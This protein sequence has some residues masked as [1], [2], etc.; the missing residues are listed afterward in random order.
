MHIRLLKTHKEYRRAEEI[1]KTVWGFNE[2]GVIPS[3]ELITIQRNGGVVL[4]AFEKDKMIGF[5]FGIVGYNNKKVYHCSRM[6]A[7]LPG[8]Q[9]KGIGF[10]LKL[11]QRRFVLRQGLELIRWTFDP[12]QS[13]NAYF[14]IRKLGVIIR[15]YAVNLYGKS[16][17]RFDKG[18]PTDRFVPEWW[19]KSDRVR[20]RIIGEEYVNRKDFY[21]ANITEIRN[22]LPI[23]KKVVLEA[24]EP[25]V[26]I[27]IPENF[28]MLKNRNIALALKWRNVSRKLFTSYLGKGYTVSDFIRRP[29]YNSKGVLTPGQKS[30]YILKK[31]AL[32]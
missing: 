1:Q 12:L 20:K 27:E 11:A 29:L 5:C 2:G 21:T 32:K 4:G 25:L 24:N 15:E 18:I 14:N 8:Y 26:A 22:G 13:K 7:V 31:I 16:T 10:A 19:I 28:D 9:D 6:L 17:S 23:P 30:F 3:N